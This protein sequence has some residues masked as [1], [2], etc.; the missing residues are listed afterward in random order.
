[1]ETAWAT[2]SRD[3]SRRRAQLLSRG[4][5]PASSAWIQTFQPNLASRS[6]RPRVLPCDVLHGLEHLS[7]QNGDGSSVSG[8]LQS[9]KADDLKPAVAEF[10]ALLAS[11]PTTRP[12]KREQPETLLQP[13]VRR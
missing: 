10:Q 13:F 11:S 7:N 12:V 5:H 4:A 1:M 8:I 6:D 2:R 9:I 3:L